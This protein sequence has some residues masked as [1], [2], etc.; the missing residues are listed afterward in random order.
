ME[1]EQ[2]K[3]D[4]VENESNLLPLQQQSKMYFSNCSK[5]LNMEYQNFSAVLSISR[6]KN[7]SFDHY[8]YD[9]IYF[10]YNNI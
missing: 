7:K 2:K 3:E 9:I 1:E 6:L 8:Y 5:I 10:R 4:E